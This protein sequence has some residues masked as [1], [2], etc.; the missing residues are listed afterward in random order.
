MG[1]TATENL[2]DWKT[3]W[4]ALNLAIA[5]LPQQVMQRARRHLLP[6]KLSRRLF[7]DF[8]RSNASELPSSIGKRLASHVTSGQRRRLLRL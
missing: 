4:R 1:M 5:H 6:G 8:D 2:I 7:S 3:C